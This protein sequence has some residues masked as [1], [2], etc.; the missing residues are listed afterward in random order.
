MEQHFDKKPPVSFPILASEKDVLEVMDDL[1]KQGARINL[2][3]IDA[4]DFIYIATVWICLNHLK[5]KPLAN[6]RLLS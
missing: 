1:K 5:K 3:N 6:L 2:E 4:N